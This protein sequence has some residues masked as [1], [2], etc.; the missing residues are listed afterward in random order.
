MSGRLDRGVLPETLR[1]ELHPTKNPGVVPEAVS[2]G[3]A[4]KLWWMC[5]QGH[6]YETT[7]MHRGRGQGCPFCSGKRALAGFN[8][9]ATT[10]P[11]LAAEWHPELNELSPAEV[12]SGSAVSVWWRGACGHSWR[13]RIN[14]RTH[15][16]GCPV[17]KGDVVLPGFND[18][19][20]RF[21][22]VAHQWDPE[23]NALSAERVSGGSNK[24]GWWLCA[25]GHSWEATINNRTA[26]GNGCPV[27]AGQLVVAGL[28][29]MATTRPD[30]AAQFIHEKNAPMTPESVFAG[31]AR[32]LWWRCELGHEW[33]ASGNT[34]TGG[35]GCAVC[36][37]QRILVGFNDLGT[38]A[39]D[40]A[41][42]WHPALNAPLSPTDVTLRNGKR[43]WWQC[44]F[45]H[46]WRTTVASRTS[47]SGCPTCAGQIVILGET[48]LSTLQP[49]VA[50]TWHPVLN[51]EV[52]PEQIHQYSNRSFW[53]LCAEGHEWKSTVNNRSH[54]QGCPVC[55]EPGFNPGK[56]GYLYFLHH[57]D[58]G[59]FKIG[60]TNVG[61]G[62]LKAFQRDGWEI[63][64]LERF[65]NGA[66][67]RV[68]ETAIKRWWRKDLAL[69]VWLTPRLMVRTGG[70]SETI[71]AE[72]ID[73]VE[74]LVRVKEEAAR[75]RASLTAH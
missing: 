36:S 32:K 5:S 71:S 42:T 66:G 65:E 33:Q 30:L 8:D 9:L 47:G 52:R 25:F 4:R 29:D 73:R 24:K 44:E 13:A 55:A 31:T 28:N 57:E 46:E 35:N 60:I 21:P 59:A 12:T 68:T 72:A 62:R 11:E 3:S 1:L 40:V 2:R 37:G 17:C 50:A 34:R 20:T 51:G 27:C 22:E 10:R 38:V 69:P 63:L 26:G 43:V 75:A 45:G 14:N 70:F 41:A 15:G 53:W 48:D 7:P 39:P 67:A 58:L 6:Q 54:G 74:A 61:T 56:P 23:R 64:H 16:T 49:R 18:L 19:A